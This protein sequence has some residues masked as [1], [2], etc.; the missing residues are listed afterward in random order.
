MVQVLINLHLQHSITARHDLL[1]TF[2]MCITSGIG[3]QRR[4]LGLQPQKTGNSQGKQHSLSATSDCCF[5][6][7]HLHLHS[8]IDL[9]ILALSTCWSRFG[10]TRFPKASTDPILQHQARA[11]Q[12]KASVPCSGLFTTTHALS[13][14][15][16]CNASASFV[17]QLISSPDRNLQKLS[18]M[19]S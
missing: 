1:T 14:F 6:C 7:S 19:L 17:R 4:E 15:A 9:S 2:F 5:I 12:D 11:L 16:R 18:L 3:C 13:N 8:I 10:F